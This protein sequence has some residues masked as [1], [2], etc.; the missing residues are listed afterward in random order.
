MILKKFSS[1]V[2][3][4]AYS[5]TIFSTETLVLRYET[6]VLR[7]YNIVSVLNT[8]YS[9]L[10]TRYYTRGYHQSQYSPVGG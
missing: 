2:Q 7:N 1:G 4:D 10:T 6:L 9:V 3:L 8:Q 5:R